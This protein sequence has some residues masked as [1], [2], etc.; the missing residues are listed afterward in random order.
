[1]PTLAP[2]QDLY[3]RAQRSYQAGESD[4]AIEQYTQLI[5]DLDAARLEKAQNEPGTANAGEWHDLLTNAASE[6]IDILRWEA[7]YDEALLQVERLID[8]SPE[9]SLALR[10]LAANL[11]IED[12]RQEEGIRELSVLARSDPGKIWG[13]I[14]LG[15]AYIWTGRYEEAE[16]ELLQAAGMESADDADRALA[17]KYLFDLYGLQRHVRQAVDTWEEACQ[18]DPKHC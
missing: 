13:W 11:K 2:Y 10:T 6:L 1:M 17:L 14:T 4:V 5:A 3:A 15:T 16:T 9:R 18:L 8:L 7:R 12:G